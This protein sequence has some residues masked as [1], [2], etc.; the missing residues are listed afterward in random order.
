MNHCRHIFQRGPHAISGGY[1]AL[2]DFHGCS[3]NAGGARPATHAGSHRSR[4]QLVENFHNSPADKSTGA[5]DK[6]SLSSQLATRRQASYQG[7]AM[8]FLLE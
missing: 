6:N 3:P 7:I 2:D 5:G 1:V 4:V 8:R